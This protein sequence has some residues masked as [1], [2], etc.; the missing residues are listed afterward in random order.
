MILRG[1]KTVELRR[2]APR[3]STDFWIAL[4]ATAP[5]RAMIGVVRARQVLV[6]T[7]AG[8]WDEVR[9]ACGLE[10]EE[11]MSYYEG[12]S[13]AVGLRLSDPIS[14]MEAI[15]LDRLRLRWPEFRPPRSFAYLPEERVRDIWEAAGMRSIH[16]AA[17]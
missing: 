8:L 11:Y 7:P 1:E 2:R 4:Y 13:R 17:G 5:E 16:G 15:P 3:C 9:E 14:L 10:H 12:A 6:S